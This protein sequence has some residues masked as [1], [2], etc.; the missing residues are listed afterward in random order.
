M[1][2]SA[3]RGRR[4][5]DL[6]PERAAC[7][8]A[9][10]GHPMLIAR[11]PA[12]GRN[13]SGPTRHGRVRGRSGPVYGRTRWMSVQISLWPTGSGVNEEVCHRYRVTRELPDRVQTVES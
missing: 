8:P 9:T 2:T 10:N 3:V 12:R 1:K 13:D 4:V 7:A 5:G 6:C 11:S